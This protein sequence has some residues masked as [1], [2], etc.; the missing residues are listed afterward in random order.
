MATKR[1][2]SDENRANALAALAGNGGNV[3]RTARELGIP[4]ATIR[5]W[6]T[7]ERHPE[8][9]QL[10]QQKKGPLADRLEEVAYQLAGLL[11]GCKCDNPQA[12]A[13]AIGILVGKLQ[14]LR[15]RPN[16]I[17]A[18]GG[19]REQKPDRLRGLLGIGKVDAAKER[20]RADG[21]GE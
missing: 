5:R 15:G 3:G 7:G 12:L 18:V 19:T 13:T 4:V 10:S 6:A 8:A 20:P 17:A 9:A 21:R 2:Y 14:I 16:S 11:P 1:R